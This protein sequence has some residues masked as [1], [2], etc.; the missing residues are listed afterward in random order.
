MITIYDVAKE[1]KVSRGT[2]SR[3]L[4]N[5]GY[6]KKD[7]RCRIER[8]AKKLNYIPDYTAQVLITKKTHIIGVLIS[9]ISNFFYPPVIKGVYDRVK[10]SAYHI[11]L[12]NSYND[13]EEEKSILR[14]FLS[15]RLDGIIFICAE[16]KEDEKTTQVLNEIMKEN[17]PIVLVQREE[18]GLLLD[19]IFVNDLEGAYVATSHLIELGHNRIGFINGTSEIIT[20]RKREEGYR[21]ALIEH[22]LLVD[23]KLILENG[24]TQESGYRG[25]EKFL[26]MKAPPTAIFTANDVIAIGAMIAIKERGKEIPKDI[27]LVG[28]D[29]IYVAALLNPPLTTVNQPKYEQGRL[30]AELLLK[31]MGGDKDSLP[32]NITLDTKLVVRESTLIK[33][34]ARNYKPLLY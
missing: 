24:F 10:E 32:E 1:A 11:I 7:T 30:A 27:A 5:K 28:F 8:A 25:I 31:R 34:Y 19:R 26:R 3:C 23:R 22:N 16:M 13:P 9:D 20:G 4:N 18:N 33:K 6:I 21:K 2:V 17:I 12:G 15:R 14:T 29:D